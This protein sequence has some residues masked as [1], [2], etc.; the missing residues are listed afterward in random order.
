MA[1][2]T[3]LITAASIVAVVL[4]SGAAVGANLG[5]LSVADAGPVGGLTV[6]AATTQA[7]GPKVIDVYVDDTNGITSQQYTVEK[8]GTIGVVATKKS[9]RLDDISVR[10]GW[11]WKLVQNAQ[12]RL[13]VTFTSKSITYDFV[14]AV[15]SGGKLTARV[16]QPVTK[17]VRSAG[18]AWTSGPASPAP[19]VNP[20]P[21]ATHGDDQGDDDD[22]ESENH[23][24][25]GDDD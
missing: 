7:G 11:T 19:R 18:T 21:T 24:G 25:G 15:D 6:S 17:T 13:T 2:R 3:A 5:I 12:K 23:E 1:H 16:V 22:G 4:A 14:A 20:A 8:A 9:V 10:P